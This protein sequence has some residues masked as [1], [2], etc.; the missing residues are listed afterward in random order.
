MAN[1][2]AEAGAEPILIDKVRASKAGHAFH[3]AW[4]ARSALELL[5]PSTN[6]VAITLEGFDT[7]D[8][9]DLGTGAV[10]IADLVRYHGHGDVANASLV[11]IVQFKYSI[12][13]SAIPLRA[14]DLAKT[15][16]KFAKADAELRSRHGDDHVRQVVRYD[17]AT[18]RPI[19]PNLIT[20]IDT[21][22]DASRSTGDVAKQRTQIGKALESYPYPREELLRRL[23]LSG[24]RGSLKQAEHALGSVIASWSEASDPESEMRLLKLRNFVRM[25]AGPADGGNNRIDRVAVLA[26]LG[27]DHEDRLYPTPDAFPPVG[28]LIERSI[29][30]E[31]LAIARAPGAP[32]IIHGAGG[33]GKTVLMQSLA[34]RMRGRDQVVI[35]DGFGAGRWRDL[36]DGRH[37]PERTLVQLANLLTGI[38]LC[39]I[40]L[41][42]SDI[43]SLLRAFRQRLAQAVRSS[44]QSDKQAGV[45]LILDAIDHAAIA[46]KETGTSSFAHALLGSLSVNPIDG[47]TVVASCR[48]ERVPQAVGSSE[49]REFEIPPFTAEEATALI[50]TRDPSANA[51]EIA[52]LLTRSGRNPRCLDTLLQDGRPYDPVIKPGEDDDTPA[53]LLD[54]LLRKRLADARRAAREKGASD[55][56][57]NL[58]LTGLALLP[59]PVPLEELAAAHGI[60]SAQVESFATDLAPLLERTT[61][62]L[63]FRD[64]PTETLIRTASVS[65][66]AS[67][68]RV[69]TTLLN[70]QS[71]SNYAARALPALLTS[72]QYIDQLIELAFDE[73]VPP[74]A[75]K[76]SQRDIRLS[77]IVA[78]LEQCAKTGKRDDLLRL[79]LEASIVAAG[80]ERSDRFLYEYPDLAAVA[81]DAEALRRLFSTRAGW[82]GGRHSA[83]GL[84]NAF[85]GDMGEARRNARRAIDWHNWAASAKG[86]SAFSSGKASTRWND[87]GFAYVEMLAGNEMR[88]AQFFAKRGDGGAYQK[89]CELFD[90]LERHRA[91]SHPPADRVMR[92]LSRCRLNSRALWAAALRYSNRDADID[93]RLLKRFAE[94]EAPTEASNTL[95]AACLNA[96]ARAIDLG[97][98]TEAGQILTKAAIAPPHV[99]DYSSYWSVDRDVDTAVVS[100]GLTAALSGK[101]V[102]LLSLAPREFLALVSPSARVRGAASFA[103]ALE[104]KL[105]E[106][107]YAHN[108]PRKRRRK[109]SIDHKQRSE[110][111]NTLNHRV[112]PL[113]P[114]AQAV[115]DIVLAPRGR[116]RRD[117]LSAA[118]DRLERDVDQASSYPYRD[119]KSYRARAGFRALFLT[120][121]TLGAIDGEIASRMTKWLTTAPGMAAP[122]LTGIVARLSR[123]GDCHNA[124]LKLASHVERLILLDTNIGSRVGSYGS[125]A[126]AVW[127]VSID[128][129]SAFFRRTLDLADAIG[130]DDF[131]RAN[132]L[133]E[134]TSHYVGP[135]LSPGA[136]HNLARIL[137]MNQHED[138]KFPW[139]EYARTMV[140]VAGLST[141]AML[142]RLDDREKTRMGLSLGAALTVLVDAGKLPADLAS[143]VF[144]LTAPI[145]SWT[146]RSSDF[147]RAA[148]QQL[149]PGQHEWLFSLIVIEIDRGD[150][151]SPARGTIE[152]LLALAEARLPVTS[153]SRARIAALAARQYPMERLPSPDPQAAVATVFEA[154]WADHDAIDRA[155]L[156]EEIGS[157]GRRWPQ[158]TIANLAHGPA[159]PAQRLKFVHAVVDANA[160]DLADKLRALDD[161]LPD[162]SANSPALKDALPKMALR[163]A[164]KHALELAGSDSDTL[165]RILIARFDADR[166]GLVEQVVASL[167]GTAEDL[168]GDLWLGLATKLAPVVSAEAFAKGLER[169]LAQS[170]ETLPRE[171]GDGPWDDR[172]SAKRDPVD[173]V[174]GLVWSRLGHS[175]AAMRW[176]GAHAVLRL[177]ERNRFDVIGQLIVRF[178]AE[179]AL[180]FGDP[181]LPFYV[182]HARLWLLIALAR[183]AANRPTQIAPHRVLLE[184]V[185]FS[186]EFPHVVMQAFA[187]DALRSITPLLESE[188]R[189]I[190]LARLVSANRSPFPYQPR[191]RYSEGRYISRPD[192]APRPDDAF[193]LDYDFNKYQVERLCHV[194]GCA[195]W[196]V[197]DVI[198]RR[199]RGWDS[200]VHGMHDCP[201]RENYED[202]WSSGTVP[203]IDRYGGYLG[204]HA[205]MLAAGEMLRSR[206]V[207]GEDWQGDA[208]AHFLAEYRLSRTD[209]RWLSEATDLFP[210]DLPRNQDFPMPDVVRRG[211]QREDHRLLTPM[212]GIVDAKLAADWMPVAGRWSLWPDTD[213]SLHTVFA[214]TDDA[215]A[216]VM[217]LL[218]DEPF[219]RWLPDDEDEIARHVAREGHSV[220]AWMDTVQN[221]ERQLDRYDPYATATALR[222]PSPAKWVR[223]QLT[224]RPD[225]PIGRTW[226]DAVGVVFRAEA[227]GAARGRGENSWEISGERISVARTRLLSL[228]NR[229]DNYLVGL[230]KV[231]RYHQNKTTGR[232]LG[233]TGAFTHRSYIFMLDSGGRIQAPLR[234]SRLAWVAVGAIDAREQREFH[235]RFQ[236]IKLANPTR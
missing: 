41:P 179:N 42:I 93:R 188:D 83:L 74:G 79:L 90:L 155:I 130:S 3:E 220:R 197:E 101:P 30:N 105:A 116:P 202:S 201:R 37:R 89:F 219:F 43:T 232:P 11:E 65:D 176:R 87:V 119:G 22:I 173:I 144:G 230:L 54:A 152:A 118:L 98:S 94:A 123:M 100:A 19:H 109:A 159:T 62:G 214:N 195:I 29:V 63:M 133:L 175:D 59:P 75:S 46:A 66:H 111:S 210:L 125:L 163:L 206:I 34:E 207:T 147:A 154:D 25:K 77:R 69:I 80:H 166:T 157:S 161:Y 56:D 193:H 115:A 92:R 81:G 225:D 217:T 13:S 216:I 143:C 24:A 227:W 35:F 120:A 31:A 127:R 140:P 17:F 203:D 194:F 117:I 122:E 189:D 110:Y 149:P 235:S 208:W 52:A 233:D 113:I 132:H 14:A 112:A 7:T 78:A 58:L 174:A 223:E 212:L 102:T 61:F 185:A 44:R 84:A 177:A 126:Q 103:K 221:A 86:E 16:T 10:E 236:A 53:G 182:M 4:A 5:L 131:D 218:T 107:Q 91:S 99:Y 129:A 181:K 85:A 178:G 162:W 142:A 213:L 6:L 71:E 27:V 36:A 32:L 148:L 141:L 95:A 76:V 128:E 234:A 139:I 9:A 38:G 8:E 72:L 135:E 1:D 39:D 192:S 60:P 168:G 226:S 12:A 231:R 172:F 136:G 198:T 114:Y 153:P 137:E 222:R 224:L 68:D 158:R 209:G 229:N 169:F 200:N 67:R 228:L 191:R 184:S 18:N 156:S 180:P 51:A 164:T 146:W 134:L 106:P 160:A 40:L 196:E 20:A 150:Q 23:L 165:W 187:I 49:H 145:E 48:T 82:P 121:D 183:L 64:E 211:S 104:Q 45:V 138:S 124:A 205:L 88:V 151:L 96:A 97:L 2:E 108:A 215:R 55:A 190:L 28:L 186:D 26:E 47:V 199:V 204:W 50:A 170:G 15:L 167:S 21:T 73:R 171:V 70:R 33:M 57:I